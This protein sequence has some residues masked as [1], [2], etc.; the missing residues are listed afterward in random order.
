MVF[1]D[2][3]SCTE[4]VSSLWVAVSGAVYALFCTQSAVEANE[5]GG[6]L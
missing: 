3:L 6:F 1:L 5:S 4:V 2:S